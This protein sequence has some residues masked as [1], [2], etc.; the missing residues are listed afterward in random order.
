ME[1][2]EV[3]KEGWL[4]KSNHTLVSS[5]FMSRIQVSDLIARWIFY[6]CRF[7]ISKFF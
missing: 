6:I 2:L 3:G 5:R 1:S 4:D 7:S